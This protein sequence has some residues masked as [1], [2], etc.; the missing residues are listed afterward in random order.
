MEISGSI[1]SSTAATRIG[2]RSRAQPVSFC[3]LIWMKNSEIA[4][5]WAARELTRIER[6]GKKITLT[7]PFAAPEFTLR[8]KAAP[9]AVPAV[10]AR[11]SGL[12][13]AS[14]STQTASR[15][16]G[17]C[18]RPAGPRARGSPERPTVAPA[19]APVRAGPA[20]STG[21]AAHPRRGAGRPTVPA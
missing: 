20:G 1:T 13:V 11:A 15:A 14:G 18:A 12:S 8:L 6:S 7:A 3:R 10:A 16:A 17:S 19:A 9:G 2:T 4:R 21:V 5:Y